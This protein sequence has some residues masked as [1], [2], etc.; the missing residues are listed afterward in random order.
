MTTNPY[1]R[2]INRCACVILPVS[3]LLIIL[4]SQAFGVESPQTLDLIMAAASLLS[5]GWLLLRGAWLFVN[6]AFD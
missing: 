4:R 1:I 2:C 5:L 6:E 3:Q